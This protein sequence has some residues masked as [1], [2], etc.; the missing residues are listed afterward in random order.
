METEGSYDIGDSSKF[1]ASNPKFFKKAL[2]GSDKDK[3]DVKLNMKL[4]RRKIILNHVDL[5]SK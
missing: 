1:H 2:V 3:F 5:K 4:R